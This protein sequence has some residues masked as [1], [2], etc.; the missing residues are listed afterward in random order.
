MELVALKQP[1][2]HAKQTSIDASDNKE[3]IFNA[4]DSSCPRTFK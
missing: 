1:Q 2:V 4:K 3:N